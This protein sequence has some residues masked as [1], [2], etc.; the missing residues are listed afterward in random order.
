MSSPKARFQETKE[1]IN[2]WS[3]LV[4]KATFLRGLDVAMLQMQ[5]ESPFSD[6]AATAAARFQRFK[7]AERFREIL[8]TLPDIPREKAPLPDINLKPIK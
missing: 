7:G 8:V 5:A 4:T 3:E 6:D 1:N 2:F